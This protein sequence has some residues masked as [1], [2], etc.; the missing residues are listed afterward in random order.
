MCYTSS[1]AC[2]KLAFMIGI[3]FLLCFFLFLLRFKLKTALFIEFFVCLYL[4]REVFRICS[5][6]VVT[7]IYGHTFN[8]A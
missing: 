5:E 3:C 8:I 1:E 2:L 4:L 6:F 7:F